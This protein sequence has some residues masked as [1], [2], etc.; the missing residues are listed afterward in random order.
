MSDDGVPLILGESNVKPSLTLSIN[1]AI[2][3][4]WQSGEVA[5]VEHDVIRWGP[6]YGADKY[7][8]MIWYYVDGAKNNSFDLVAEIVTD[9]TEFPLSEFQLE[10]SNKSHTYFI[11]VRGF[12]N[13]GRVVARS[14]MG[15]IDGGIP[16][17]LDGKK[18]VG[19]IHDF[20]CK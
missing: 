6:V 20:G 17:S 2:K 11:E 18:I 7:L 5:D 16:F 3:I 1:K 4:F 19:D 10:K 13:A 14:T 8:L 12:S 15:S 9:K